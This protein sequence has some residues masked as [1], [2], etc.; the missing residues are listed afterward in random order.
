MSSNKVGPNGR[1]SAVNDPDGAK[2][3]RKR[4]RKVEEPES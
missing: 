4:T 2:P 3:R 1:K